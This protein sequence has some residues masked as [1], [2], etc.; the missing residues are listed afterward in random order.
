MAGDAGACTGCTRAHVER[1]GT[2]RHDAGFLRTVRAVL[3]HLAVHRRCKLGTR[4]AAR[5]GVR[6]RWGAGVEGPYR[7]AAGAAAARLAGLGS[8]ALR[9][10]EAWRR[11]MKRHERPAEARQPG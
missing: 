10:Q 5:A 4:M 9:S 6:T 11:R 3:V 2:R 8:C 7:R 1:Q